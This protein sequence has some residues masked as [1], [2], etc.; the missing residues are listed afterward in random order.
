MESQIRSNAE[1]V[2]K[3]A[4]E[5]LGVDVAYDEAG[6]RWL[7]QY[8][9]SQRESAAPDVKERLPSTLGSYLG[10]C[11]RQSFG[12]EWVQDPEAGWAVRV[13][14]KLTVYPFNKVRKQL[15]NAEGDSVSSFFATIPALLHG[16]PTRPGEPRET[17]SKR[18]W[19]KF[20]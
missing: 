12:G 10:E 1:L 9:N 5:S 13:N 20:W 2:R 19:W 14:D 18:S 8:I 16:K 17:D 11:V 7:D 3:V 4:R 15:S 6:V